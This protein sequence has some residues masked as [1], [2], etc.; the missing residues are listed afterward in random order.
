MF[1]KIVTEVLFD[2]GVTFNIRHVDMIMWSVVDGIV[3]MQRIVPDLMTCP[4]FKT[5]YKTVTTLTSQ[6]MVLVI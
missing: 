6:I 3:V 5:A 2:K 4:Y 1:Y